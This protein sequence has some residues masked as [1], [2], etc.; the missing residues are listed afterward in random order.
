VDGGYTLFA[1]GGRVLLLDARCCG[2]FYG[3]GSVTNW[4]P[5]PE[6]RRERHR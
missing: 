2:S 5:P 1:T 6:V 3:A 4:T